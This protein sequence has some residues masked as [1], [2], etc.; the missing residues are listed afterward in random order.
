MGINKNVK[1]NNSSTTKTVLYS[2]NLLVIVTQK[3]LFPS[4]INNIICISI[5]PLG[6]YIQ[7]VLDNWRCNK[8][9]HMTQFVWP[10]Q[11]SRT[12]AAGVVPLSSSL[13]G[14]DGG[15]VEG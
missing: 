5:V 9:T 1:K 2:L 4:N 3:Q 6:P 11:W 7:G 14:G 10:V 13:G 15:M 8:V 12:V